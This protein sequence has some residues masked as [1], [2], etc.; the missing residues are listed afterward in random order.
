MSSIRGNSR[1][2]FLVRRV[3]EFILALLTRRRVYGLENVPER[4]P[5]LVIVNH[6]SMV[7][8]PLVMA[9]LPVQM[10][11][12]AASTHRNDFFI[13]ELMNQVGAIWVKRGEA[14]R[15][16]LRT[17]LDLLA[18]GGI[19]GLAP[20]GTRSKTNALQRGRVGAAYLATRAGVP[21][22]PVV[23]TGT[24]TAFATVKKFKRPMLT[25][26]IGKPFRLPKSGRVGTDELELYTD[27]I[28]RVLAA[29]L[30]EKYRGVYA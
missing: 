25:V 3:I 11:V 16:A 1:T 15:Q 2:Y 30:P 28:M 10:T 24:D 26:T 7:D 18:A 5:Y 20:E 6:M 22:L 13:G 12:F 23:V 17:A 9:T 8:P 4:G 14:D 21:L 27:Q 19:M 29:M